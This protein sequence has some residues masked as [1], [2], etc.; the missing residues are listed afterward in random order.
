[1]LRLI[2]SAE[3]ER[4]YFIFK[5]VLPQEKPISV[6]V[7]FCDGEKQLNYLELHPEEGAERE[8]QLQAGAEGVGE[9]VFERTGQCRGS[10]GEMAVLGI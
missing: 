8:R 10:G 6:W 4:E 9:E 3:R 2:A 5:I 1:M 7:D